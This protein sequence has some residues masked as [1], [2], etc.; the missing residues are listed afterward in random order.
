M[1]IALQLVNIKEIRINHD[2]MSLLPPQFKEKQYK[3]MFNYLTMI[4]FE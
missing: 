1:I 2:L 4:E 3:L